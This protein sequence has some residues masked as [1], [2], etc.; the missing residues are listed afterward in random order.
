MGQTC[1]CCKGNKVAYVLR[2]ME[3]SRAHE[4]TQEDGCEVLYGRSGCCWT[5]HGSVTYWC[6]CWW[7]LEQ[8]QAVHVQDRR[9]RPLP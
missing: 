1:I 7:R 5:D 9:P 2:K 6:C 4:I 8:V 3:Q